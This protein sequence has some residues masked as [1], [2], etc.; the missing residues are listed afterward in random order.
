MI[1]HFWLNEMERLT[2]RS[3]YKEKERT[4]LKQLVIKD[5][6]ANIKTK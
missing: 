6:L 2:I 1:M 5:A 4:Q 3:D